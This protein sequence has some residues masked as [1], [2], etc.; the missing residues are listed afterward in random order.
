MRSKSTAETASCPQCRKRFTKKRH[1]RIRRFC[2]WACC[3]AWRHANRMSRKERLIS[4]R[5][6]LLRYGGP[7]DNNG[8]VNWTGSTRGGYGRL[9]AFPGAHRMVHRNVTAHRVAYELAFGTIPHG[10]LV[11]HHCDNRACVNPAH[12]F[13]GTH[14]ANKAD[15]VAK[16]RHV[17]GERSPRHKLTVQQVI[18]IRRRYAEGGV[19]KKSLGIEYHVSATVV[20]HILA[21]NYWKC[22]LP[23]VSPAPKPGGSPYPRRKAAGH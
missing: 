8:C 11:L 12:L 4:L 9:A 7:P 21:G 1:G 17:H 6:R 23:S 5:E 10:A 15:S 3:V 16:N 22:C 19:T 13:L 14:R 20:W 18:E 2:S